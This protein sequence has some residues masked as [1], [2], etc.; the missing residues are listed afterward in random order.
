VH[1]QVQD[2]P[3]SNPVDTKKE[4]SAV[5]K[6]YS[7]PAIAKSQFKLQT[8]TATPVPITG[9]AVVAPSG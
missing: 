2:H 3:V 1:L 9:P 4:G 7:K 8:V 6:T 5:K